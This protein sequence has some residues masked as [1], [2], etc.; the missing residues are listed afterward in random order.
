MAVAFF[1]TST[2]V[3]AQGLL[4]K[5]KDKVNQTVSGGKSEGGKKESAK[6]SL[7]TT[8]DNLTYAKDSKNIS[9]IYYSQKALSNTHENEMGMSKTKSY[10]KF[11]LEFNELKGIISLKSTDYNK[12]GVH[13][14]GLRSEDWAKYL[15]KANHISYGRI[16][17]ANNIYSY[18]DIQTNFGKKE[19]MDFALNDLYLT[20]LEPGI[21]AMHTLVVL[22]GGNA[23][24]CGKSEFSNN[25]TYSGQKFNLLY[26]S[27]ADISK[28]TQEKITAKIFE[29]QENRCKIIN[30]GL[31]SNASMPNKVAGFKDEPTN[32]ALLA[33]ANLRAKNGQYKEKILNVYASSKWTNVYEFL[34]INSLRTLTKRNMQIAV[35]FK[36]PDGSCSFETMVIEQANNYTTGGINEN[37]TGQPI[38]AVANSSPN[39]IDCAKIKK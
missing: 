8:L 21:F 15:I 13:E 34:G 20:Q 1:I 24:T 6:D 12:I 5:L 23:S 30:G 38:L 37:F 31:S 22:V 16:N 25:E 7:D 3:N 28:W 18:K 29:M 35:A 19:T 2:T 9:G 11:L 39:V 33:A 36:A 14:F 27:G 10:K 17:A 26:K 4:G 32:S